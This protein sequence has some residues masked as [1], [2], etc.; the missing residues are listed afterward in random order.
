MAPSP[1][2]SFPSSAISGFRLNIAS[3]V[4]LTFSPSISGT[5]PVR[6]PGDVC[7]RI[8]PRRRFCFVHGR[9]LRRRRGWVS[10]PEPAPFVSSIYADGR[11]D[12]VWMRWHDGKRRDEWFSQSLSS[13]WARCD[14][15]AR[16]TGDELGALDFDV[17][18]NSQGL[19]VKT[20]SV[21]TLSRDASHASVL[22]KLV[23][24]NWLRKSERENEIRYDL[25]W[26]RGRWLIDDMHSVIE[27]R[28]WSLRAIL[29]GYLSR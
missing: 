16:R 2:Q 22:V 24:D 5:N 3:A 9:I 29:A 25:V 10:H 11:E 18:T 17:A 12:D 27:P 23:P 26:Q 14:A 1:A 7:F 13:L 4:S 20:F 8:L 21:R 28:S 15:M 19:D 6:L